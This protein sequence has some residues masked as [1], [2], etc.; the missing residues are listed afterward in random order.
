MLP[1]ANITKHLT[2]YLYKVAVRVN[3]SYCVNGDSYSQAR[4]Q[5]EKYSEMKL[6]PFHLSPAKVQVHYHLL[7]SATLRMKDMLEVILENFKL[8]QTSDLHLG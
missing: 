4:P 3:Y 2:L 6:T 1:D 8:V 7:S 5:F